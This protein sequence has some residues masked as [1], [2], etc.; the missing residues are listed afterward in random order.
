MSDFG[1]KRRQIEEKP[2]NFKS[3]FARFEGGNSQEPKENYKQK[4]NNQN[5]KPLNQQRFN[6]ISG[7][8]QRTTS[9]ENENPL[10]N[11]QSHIKSN[12]VNNNPKKETLKSQTKKGWGTVTNKSTGWGTNKNAGWGTNKQNTGWGNKKNTGWGTNKQSTGWGNK[13]SA[14][15]ETNKQNTGWGNKTNT[16]WGTNKQ[17]TGWGNKK[18]SE[19]ENQQKTNKPRRRP[20]EIPTIHKPTNQNEAN[21]SNKKEDEPV[22]DLKYLVTKDHQRISE[23]IPNV[24][25]LTKGEIVQ[26]ISKTEKDVWLKGKDSKGNVGLFHLNYVQVQPNNIQDQGHSQNENEN[27]NE[28]ENQN[29]IS[30]KNENGNN[31]TEKIIYIA[32]KDYQNDSDQ[33]VLVLKKGD[34]IEFVSKTESEGWMNGK[35]KN[36]KIGYFYINFVYLKGE[37]LESSSSDSDSNSGTDSVDTDSENEQELESESKNKNKNVHEKG[38]DYSQKNLLNTP[39]INS[40]SSSNN[41]D[42]DSKKIIYLVTQNYKPPSSLPSVLEL[43]KGEEIEFISD[44]KKSGWLKGKNKEGQIGFIFRKGVTLKKKTKKPIPVISKPQEN[45]NKS[46]KKIIYVAIRNFLNHQNIPGALF[47]MKGD[48]IEFLSKTSKPLWYEGKDSSGKRGYFPKDYA[49]LKTGNPIVK[50]NTP[51]KKP[52][53][54]QSNNFNAKRE[55][56]GQPKNELNSNFAEYDEKKTYCKATQTFKNPEQ[57]KNVLVFEKGMMIE[58]IKKTNETWWK[59]TLNGQEGYFPVDHIHEI[60]GKKDKV[61]YIAL[62]DFK[63]RL[64]KNMLDFKKGDRIEFLMETTKKGK[65]LKGKHPNGNI[66]FFRLK[67]VKMEKIKSKNKKKPKISKSDSNVKKTVKIIKVKALQDFQEKTAFGKPLHFK[68]GEII[69]IVQKTPTGWWKGKINDRIGFFPSKVVVDLSQNKKTTVEKNGKPEKTIPKKINLQKILRTET[70]VAKD[71]KNIFSYTNPQTQTQT[72][73]QTQTQII[74]QTQTQTQVAQQKEENSPMIQKTKTK[75]NNNTKT[76]TK[77]DPKKIN[78]TKDKQKGK[79]KGKETKTK[80]K[81]KGKEK[82]KDKDKHKGKGKEKGKGKNKDKDKQKGKGKDKQKDKQKGKEKGKETKTKDKLKG[83]EKGKKA[84][85]KQK[86]K[87]NGKGKDKHKGKDKQKGKEKD[88]QKDKQKGKGKGK[89]KVEEINTLDVNTLP[90]P[91]NNLDNDLPLPD[92]SDLELNPEPIDGLDLETQKKRRKL[93]LKMFRRSVKKN[94]TTKFNPNGIDL[95]DNLPLPEDF[96]LPEN[97]PLPEPLAR[98]QDLPKD[99]PPPN[100]GPEKIIAHSDFKNLHN[101]PNALTFKKNEEIL[102]ITKSSAIGW[103]NGKNSKGKEGI[104]PNTHFHF[105]WLEK[106]PIITPKPKPPPEIKIEAKDKE[107]DQTESGIDKEKEMGKEKEKEEKKEIIYMIAKDTYTNEE[108]RVGVMSFT[109]DEKIIW[110]KKKNKDWFLGQN[111]KDEKGYYPTN[112][113]IEEKSRNTQKDIKNQKNEI[114]TDLIIK[115]TSKEKLANELNVKGEDKDK[116]K[117]KGKDQDNNKG[118]DKDIKNDKKNKDKEMDKEKNKDKDN[119]KDKDK[120]KANQEK[121]K[122]KDKNKH[123]NKGKVKDIKKDKKNKDKEM[124]KDKKEDKDQDKDKDKD[125]NKGKDKDLKKNKKNKDT[126]TDQEKDKDKDKN[127]HNKKDKDKDIKKDKKDRKNKDKEMDK[128]KNRDKGK[129]KVKNKDKDKDKKKKKKPTKLNFNT[130]FIEDESGWAVIDIRDKITPKKTTASFIDSKKE[131]KQDIKKK[132]DKNFKHGKEKE[133]KKRINAKT[134]TVSKSIDK[135]KEVEDDWAEIDVSVNNPKKT[136]EKTTTGNKKHQ[137]NFKKVGGTTGTTNT[138]TNASNNKKKNEKINIKKIKTDNKDDEEDA[139]AEVSIP[140]NSTSQKINSDKLFKKTNSSRPISHSKKSTK[141]RNSKHP[142]NHHHHHR[143]HKKKTIDKRSKKPQKE[144]TKPKKNEAY[145]KEEWVGIQMGIDGDFDD[146]W[147]EFKPNNTPKQNTSPK[148]SF[149]T[150]KEIEENER[151]RE[152]LK[153]KIINNKREQAKRRRREREKQKERVEEKENENENEK[154]KE[155]SKEKEKE[156]EKEK[157]KEKVKEKMKQKQEKKIKAKD[158]KEQQIEKGKENE[159]EK[160][161]GVSKEHDNSNTRKVKRSSSKNNHH[162]HHSR[163]H[164]HHKAQDSSKHHSKNK[165]K[166]TTTKKN[167]IS[168]AKPKFLRTIKDFNNPKNLKNILIFKKGEIL[169]VVKKPNE[170]WFVAQ[171]GEKRG[172]V[173]VD[174]V[175][176]YEK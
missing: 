9:R 120:G 122:D 148:K 37:K 10:E 172:Y 2:T 42:D 125:N 62:K 109:K 162:H 30:Q 72:K 19:Q 159:K 64:K 115:T 73:T 107:Q 93:S 17:S 91:T 59:G 41:N 103:F 3:L 141:S 85:D 143:H 163:N 38:K 43:I 75:A 101:L 81:L 47:F 51:I 15:K 78:K 39:L 154:E 50:V 53:Q 33:N 95:P 145:I 129:D 13:Q 83:K 60:P 82:G 166:N 117:N 161:K 123:N 104:C 36:G 77:S 5:R 147:A 121:D 175:E 8:N 84:K 146:L 153:Q 160:E 118:K 14:G 92:I 6:T 164:R 11:P 165:I 156:K 168:K 76:E 45:N 54:I 23:K 139:W 67:H 100:F 58:L 46:N 124:D 18:N 29:N 149:K 20:P 152:K 74:T 119:K 86:E 106:K 65:L 27:E 48:E 68:A 170:R 70:E 31:I 55:I 137:H 26:L 69:E 140:K 116:D 111:E 1:N 66:G 127:K 52:N 22:Q 108:K 133:E 112:Y 157:D 169:K 4:Q 98:N 63:K 102:Y 132:D 155:K 176:I 32:K 167:H 113:F 158:V 99:L 44:T 25:P 150:K 171:L 79:E 24:L 128:D 57:R 131:N 61:Y 49:R 105:P 89:G 136:N 34:E 80:D 7:N 71:A 135:K 16:G 88:K 144:Y 134:K 110:K 90:L 126:G 97:L 87:E 12:L 142:H 174:C 96:P 138:F 28:N 40:S 114:E 56:K 173:P 151:R 130:T 94:K 21:F 35:L